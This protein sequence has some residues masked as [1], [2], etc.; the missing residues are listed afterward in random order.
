MG[1]KKKEEA[2]LK[3]PYKTVHIPIPLHQQLSD[4]AH[5]AS[6]ATGRTI[7]MRDIVREKLSVPYKKIKNIK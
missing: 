2:A 5:D 1:S 6:K 3:Q 7:T 4:E